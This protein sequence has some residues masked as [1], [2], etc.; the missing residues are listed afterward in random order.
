MERRPGDWDCMKCG[1]VVFAK[2]NKCFKCG[3]SRPAGDEANSGRND[4][5]KMRREDLCATFQG[6]RDKMCASKKPRTG[7]CETPMGQKNSQPMLK[8]RSGDMVERYFDQYFQTKDLES[9]INS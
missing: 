4:T 3:A 6:E 1:S 7:D 8:P 5:D 9:Q 2:K